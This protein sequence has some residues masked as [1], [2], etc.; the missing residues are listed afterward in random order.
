VFYGDSE[1]VNAGIVDLDTIVKPSTFGLMMETSLRSQRSPSRLFFKVGLPEGASLTQDTA[2]SGSVSV[3]D[4]GRI[5]AVIY[6]PIAHDAEGTVVPV[7]MVVEGDMLVLTV[8]HPAG[9]YSYPITVDPRYEYEPHEWTW[10]SQV[11]TS[12]S[13]STNWHFEK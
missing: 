13:H 5:L 3:V 4:A 1:N 7:G 6:A 9:A 12:G 8:D 11:N 10:D 2:V